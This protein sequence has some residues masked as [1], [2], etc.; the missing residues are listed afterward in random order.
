MHARPDPVGARRDCCRR[1]QVRIGR[2]YAGHEVVP[3]RRVSR[4][5]IKSDRTAAVLDRGP[6]TSASSKTVQRRQQPPQR[7]RA[8]AA[9]ARAAKRGAA[10]ENAHGVQRPQNGVGGGENLVTWLQ[11]C[12]TGGE[13]PTKTTHAGAGNRGE[14]PPADSTGRSAALP[15]ALLHYSRSSSPSLRD[16][17][18]EALASAQVLREST[19]QGGR[20]GNKHPT[21]DDCRRPDY[22]RHL[23]AIAH[24]LRQR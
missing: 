8:A 22:C 9:R 3:V 4:R 19:K 2:G 16:A 18:S 15:K 12:A 7:G 14:Q 21:R 17:L 13:A 23:A 11:C 10:R 1:I 6:T 5:R 24:V 20:R